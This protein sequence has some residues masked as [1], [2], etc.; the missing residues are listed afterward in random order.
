MEILE[1][2]DLT[3]SFRDAGELAGCSHH[4]VAA[5]V[6]ARD[7]GAPVDRGAVRPQLIDAYLA[8]VEEW[9]EK[10]SGKIRADRAHDTTGCSPW[11][12]RVL[13]GPP[14]GRSRS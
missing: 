8:K 5:H 10:S 13:S 14:G 4:T 9:V 12:M 3:G 6:A 7:A 11:V 1:A 2:Y